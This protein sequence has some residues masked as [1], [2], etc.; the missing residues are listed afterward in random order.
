MGASTTQRAADCQTPAFGEGCPHAAH[1]RPSAQ[2]QL[3]ANRSCDLRLSPAKERPARRSPSLQPR[4]CSVAHLPRLPGDSAL[5]PC[6]WLSPASYSSIS[7]PPVHTDLQT[8]R[9]T[10]VFLC[11]SVKGRSPRPRTVERP[12]CGC[13]PL[14]LLLSC[15]SCCR[16][17]CRC[18]CFLLPLLLLLLLL[19]LACTV[20]VLD[21]SG[22]SICVHLLPYPH[23]SCPYYYS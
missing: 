6:R 12:F 4:A 8:D 14:H 18:R 1:A 19:L 11:P 17:R 3:P 20:A 23:T 13:S 9:Q 7:L 16:C 5:L 10:D 15:S 2:E 22:Q 21:R